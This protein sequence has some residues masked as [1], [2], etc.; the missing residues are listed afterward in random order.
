MNRAIKSFIKRRWIFVLIGM[1]LV[2]SLSVFIAHAAYTKT[3]TA[4]L[5]V[6][7]YGETGSLFS[8]NYLQPQTVNNIT[9]AYIYV[10]APDEGKAAE[11][12][13]DKVRISNF[14]QGNQAVFYDRA[15]NYSLSMKLVYNNNGTY[16]TVSSAN[17]A[18]IIGEQWIKASVGGTDYIFGYD[19]EHSTPENPVYL[20]LTE[21]TASSSL[22]GRQSST[23]VIEVMYSAN[24]V[25]EL[26]NP[27]TPVPLTKLYLEVTATPTPSSAYKDINPIGARLCLALAG[28]VDA[29]NWEGYFNDEPG[30]RN[31][32][33]DG[34][35]VNVSASLDGYNYVIEGVGSASVTIKWNT[36][37]LE[38]NEGFIL[39]TL[40]QESVP[41]ADE[42]GIKTLSFTVDSRTA[43]RYDTQFYRS[44][45][46]T[47]ADYDTWNKLVSYV[48][49]EFTKQ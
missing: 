4:K 44:G 5:V 24:Q 10:S 32:K 12:S 8:S 1:A 37:Y 45:T 26:I 31:V 41:V 19:A 43:S 7:R 34:T 27:S 22:R 13:G 20:N 14:A 49:F 46:K 42:N 9:T 39:D 17:A 16:E 18:T 11:D 6:A 48:T 35:T 25:E 15:I 38:L 28:T 2:L 30:A 21:R 29:T 3:N 40:G 36:N 23:D 33:A 47:D